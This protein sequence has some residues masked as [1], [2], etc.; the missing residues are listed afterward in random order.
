[1]K[2]SIRTNSILEYLLIVLLILDTNSLYTEHFTGILGFKSLSIIILSLLTI[3]NISSSR[4]TRKSLNKILI[5]ISTVGVLA[6]IYIIKYPYGLVEYILNILII[7]PLATLYGIYLI[8]NK[9]LHNFV[10][11]FCNIVVVI[12]SISLF[13]WFFG[14]ILNWIRPNMYISSGWSGYVRLYAGYYGLYFETQTINLA[15]FNG[16]R[17]NGIFIEGPMYNFVLT[18][19]AIYL[20]IVSKSKCRMSIIVLTIITTLSTTGII[21]YIAMVF[22]KTYIQAIFIN[23]K[24][25]LLQTSLITI[26]VGVGFSYFYIFITDKLDSVSSIIRQDDLYS[27]IMSWLNSIFVGNGY[28]NIFSIIEFMDG[29]IRG[30]NFGY[31]NG[32]MSVLSDGGLVLFLIIFFPIVYC[33]LKPIVSWDYKMLSVL[34]LG[35]LFSTIVD[36]KILFLVITGITYSLMLEMN[37]SQLVIKKS[38]LKERRV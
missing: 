22:Y 36:K 29:T 5:Y 2:M 27:G 28:G 6:I 24:V 12:A 37:T 18:I 19:T 14:S 8:N 4:L 17:N 11:K 33:I 16:W 38:I 35:L 31:S 26:F 9:L 15:G 7:I 20:G 23:K 3:L 30:N 32:I 21:L 25:K 1:M 13:F 10:L 34:W